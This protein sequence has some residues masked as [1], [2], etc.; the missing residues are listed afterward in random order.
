MGL[1]VGQLQRCVV[2]RW[3]V[4]ELAGHGQIAGKGAAIFVFCVCGC[5]KEKGKRK[6]GRKKKKERGAKR[7]NT[8]C[9]Q[10]WVNWRI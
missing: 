9:L 1:I 7:E 8:G 6:E 4:L 2:W 5:R 3:A 10:N